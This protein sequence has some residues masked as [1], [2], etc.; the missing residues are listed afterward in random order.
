MF[1]LVELNHLNAH[2]FLSF[3]QT[4]TIAA[5]GCTLLVGFDLYKTENYV[6]LTWTFRI[7]AVR[8][9][10]SV[11]YDNGREIVKCYMI[12]SPLQATLPTCYKDS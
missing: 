10:S 11:H 12:A 6:H 5:E 8:Y 4:G 7:S 9:F 1:R 3:M 2:V